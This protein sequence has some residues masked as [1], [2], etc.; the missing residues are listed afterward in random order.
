MKSRY[1]IVSVI[2]TIAI[3]A[4]L[5]VVVQKHLEQDK[6]DMEWK[7]LDMAILKIQ[8]EL[9]K[10]QMLAETLA[11]Y[12]E[13]VSI[14]STENGEFDNFVCS[15]LLIDTNLVG[16]WIFYEPFQMYKD[17]FHFG[18][19][20]NKIKGEPYFTDNN[21]IIYKKIKNYE[22]YIDYTTEGWYL[23]GINP[24]GKAAWSGIFEDV[25]VNT[26]M[27]TVSVPFFREQKIIGVAGTDMSI[28]NIDKVVKHLSLE[29]G[30]AFLLSKDGFYMSSWDNSRELTDN[31]L[32]DTNATLKQ[33]GME[34]LNSPKNSGKYTLDGKDY[35]VHSAI[36]PKVDW[37]L[38]ILFEL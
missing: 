4:V 24:N 2:A 8:D 35:I 14:S 13:S 6:N 32:E 3:F 30:K 7:L 21:G 23:Q 20:A 28:D 25:T 1:I 26:K 34:M 22:D 16:V 10:N 15:S 17:K 19:Y 36:I 33:I 38:I 37:N 27:V 11:K 31:I 29:G 12:G 5:F 9:D 18:V